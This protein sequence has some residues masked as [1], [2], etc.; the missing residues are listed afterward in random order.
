M[1][2]K[3]DD[4]EGSPSCFDVV[5]N[6]NIEPKHMFLCLFVAWFVFRIGN[7]KN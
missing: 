1:V 2:T 6:N 3:F 7:N 4:I 5:N